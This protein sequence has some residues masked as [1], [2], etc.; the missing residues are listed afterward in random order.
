MIDSTI[1]RRNLIGAAAGLGVAA[2]ASSM[3][4]A[5]PVRAEEAAAPAEPELLYTAY[6]N[7]Q[8]TD[9]RTNTKELTTLFSPWKLGKYEIANRMCKSAA[10]SA[11]YLAG[12]TPEL[13]QYYVNFAK[14][15]VPLIWMEN[16]G[17]MEPTPDTGAPT[18]E[19]VAFGQALTAECAQYGAYMGYQWA[20][21]GAVPSSLTLEAIQALEQYGANLAKGLQEMGFIGI[22]INAAGFNQGEQF[23]S[24]YHNDRTDEYGAGSIENRARFVCECVQAIKAACGEDF[25]IQVLID[26]IE[27]NDN[28]D[29]NATLMNLDHTLT[30]TRNKPTTC[31]EGIALAKC[32]EAAGADSM[33][34]RLGPLNNHLCQFGSDMYFILSGIEGATGYGTQY[35]FKQHWQGLLDGEHN[36]CG[37]THEVARRYKEQL[38]IPCGVVTFNDPAH[39]PDFFETALAEGKADFYLM[40]RPL[41]VDFDYVNKLREG[42][43]DE[44]AP[45]TRCLHCHI[46]SNE[47]NSMFGYCRVNP[48]TQRVMR[49]GGPETYELPAAEVA[50][51]V[52]VI[53]AGPAGLEAAAIAAQRGHNVTLFEKAGML[54]GKLAFAAAVKG[55]HENLNDLSAY[56]QRQ[57]ELA[58]VTVELGVEVTAETIAEFAPDA[59]ILACGGAHVDLGLAGESF[60]VVSLEGFMFEDLGEHVV[61]YGSNAQAFDTALWLTVHKKHVTMVT[62]D[63]ADALDTQQSQH[64]MRFITT[65]LYSLGMQVYTGASIVATGDHEITIASSEA[66]VE[67]TLHCDSIV[68]A[69][70]DVANTALIDGLEVETYAVGDCANP[71]NIARA[72]QAGYDAGRAV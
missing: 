1:S 61:V 11:T 42:R 5:E 27:D 2:A 41:T 36:G 20:P 47:L 32:I 4:A 3:I 72:I 25:V 49:A 62:P 31:E 48:L 54:G 26:C 68:D 15:G 39:A 57:V 16:V 24:R 45:C 46:G 35:N 38:S 37:M 7:P 23:L 65:A 19:A 33:H 52:M 10:G 28:L 14:G 59:V 17:A 34:L 22:E 44:I 70:D 29:N 8:C 63:S 64:M 67:Y 69:S 60:K 58:G 9:Y 12:L 40:T 6:V 66:G 43:I 71:F 56:L 30:L 13:H 18:A 50:K 53:G 51:K 55:P 21:F